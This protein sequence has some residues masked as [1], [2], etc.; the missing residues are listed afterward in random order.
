MFYLALICGG[1]AVTATFF[2][3]AM[4]ISVIIHDWKF[5]REDRKRARGHEVAMARLQRNGDLK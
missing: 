4:F 1:F 2:I 3:C 5:H